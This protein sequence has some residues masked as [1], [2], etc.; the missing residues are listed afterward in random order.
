MNC[1]QLERYAIEFTEGAAFPEREAVERHLRTCTTC[2]ERLQGFSD[3][4]RLLDGWEGIQPSASFDAR[5]G[6]RVAA[7]PAAAGWW[8]R[9]TEEW[10]RFPSAS[11]ALAGAVLAIV[12]A[13]VALVRY[14]P[15]SFPT[16]E[17]QPAPIAVDSTGPDELALYQDLPVLEDWDML[18]NF[19][20][21]QE[22]NGKTP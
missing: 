9:L 21:L 8:E 10:L 19:E 13:A 16:T 1:K 15:S 4:S 11:P 14:Y 2:A 6:Q 5:L 20:V 18:S 22:L 7:Q 12:L 17:P 3:V